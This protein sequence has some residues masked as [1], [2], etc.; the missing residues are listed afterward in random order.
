[1]LLRSWEEGGPGHEM[2]EK[3]LRPTSPCDGPSSEVM[4]VTLQ[5][6]LRSPQSSLC[7]KQLRGRQHLAYGSPMVVRWAA[8]PRVA[9]VCQ[10]PGLGH[11]LLWGLLVPLPV[12]HRCGQLT[13]HLST[14]EVGGPSLCSCTGP[15][16]SW[17]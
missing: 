5:A 11:R 7:P 16:R 6:S 12:P 3:S 10:S 4:F 2:R 13:T 15:G 1:M 9:W 8:H 14:V 17:E